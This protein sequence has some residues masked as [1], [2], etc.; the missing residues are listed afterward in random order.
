MRS[1]D[2]PQAHRR[3]GLV[4]YGAIGALVGQ[5]LLG[6]QVPGL[7]LVGVVADRGAPP[8]LAVG[9][10]ETLVEASDI[11]VEAAGARALSEFASLTL[12]R[13]RTLV[14]LSTGAFLD[15]AMWPLLSPTAA[16]GRLILSTG[17]IAGLDLIRAARL[18]GD[19]VRVG[20]RSTKRPH[21]LIQA[22][23]D[24]AEHDRLV[25]LT[26]ADEPVTVFRGGAIEAA[27]LFPANLNVAAAL[28]IAANDPSAVNVELVADA[29]TPQTRHEVTIQSALGH[30]HVAIANQPSQDNPATSGLVPWAVLRCL[31]DLSPQ[32]AAI[33]L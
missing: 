4:G 9:D 10:V 8:E 28:A 12:E 14:A 6:G 33:I 16:K 22:W 18:A 2:S 1:A 24:Q 30:Y 5:A 23:M 13:G 3:V 7:N 31:R 32:A 25:S 17:A 29:A 27:R 20:L 11:I 26:A 21:A 19:D 15:P